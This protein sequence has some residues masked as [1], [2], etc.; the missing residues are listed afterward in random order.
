M[1]CLRFAME[2]GAGL[3]VPLIVQRSTSNLADMWAGAP[4]DLNYM[5]D[6]SVFAANIKSACPQMKVYETLTDIKKDG[7]VDVIGLLNMESDLKH[8]ANTSL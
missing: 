8:G 4:I 3:I 6:H 2:A 1:T 5:F 7:E